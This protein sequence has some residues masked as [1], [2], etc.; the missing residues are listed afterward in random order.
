[1]HTLR[2]PACVV[3]SLLPIL[4]LLP[5]HAQTG[6][7]LVK[8]AP[9]LSGNA[10]V[11]GSIQ[12][13]QPED[14]N[15][16]GNA[17]LTQKL[18]VPGTPK[19]RLNGS[20]TYGGLQAGTGSA[21]PAGTYQITLSGNARLGSLVNRTNAVVLPAMAAPPVSAG[22]RVVVIDAGGQSA[23]D[24]STVRELKVT[25]D[26][27][28][29]AV[30]PG[31]Y[32][33]LQ[34]DG[35]TG[36]QL[37]VAGSAT[38]LVYNVDQLV[39][40]GSAQ[41]QVLSPVI[42][43]VRTKVAIESEVVLGNP[44]HP[45]WLR[46]N[47]YE[48]GLR[49][50][51][52]AQVYARV[53]A[54]TSGND[55]LVKLDGQALLKGSI[56][57][58]WLEVQGQGH[59]VLF[60]YDG[61]TPTNHPPMANA[62]QVQATEDTPEAVALTGS[63]PDGDALTFTITTPPAH[64]ALSG[65]APALIYTP[66][67]NYSGP[68]AFVFKVNDGQLDSALA[69]VSLN[70][71]AVNDPPVA[72]AQTVTLAEDDS[73]TILL[74]GTDVEGAVLSFQV[75]DP[76]A[77]GTLSGTGAEVTYTPVANFN[78]TDTFRFVS[79]DGQAS[80][81]PASVTLTITPV[82][83][84][85]LAVRQSLSTLED[86]PL[87]VMLS[88][89]DVDGD[90]L[91]CTITQPPA[92]GTLSG[93]APALIYTPAGNFN[94]A[95]AFTFTVS[96]G[97]LTAQAAVSV[98]VGP[99]NDAPFVYNVSVALDEDTAASIEGDAIDFDFDALAFTAI[100]QPAH[101]MLTP[102]ATG[103]TYTPAANFNGTDSFTYR[104]NDGLADSDS[105]TVTLTVRAVND[106]PVA[107]AGAFSVVEDTPGAIGLT[108]TDV[109]GDTLSFII[110][111]QPPHGTLTLQSTGWSYAPEA[112]WSGTDSFTFKASDGQLESA[113]ATATVE[114]IS[115]NDAP[116]A[117]AQSVVLDED[118]PASI[119]LTGGD[120]EDSPLS[121]VVLTL[122]AHGT[123]TGDAP[124]LLY[125]PFTDYN[126]SDAFSFK[127]NDGTDDSPAATISL[128][129]NPVN[130]A[131]SGE[132]LAVV[133][134]EDG[135]AAIHLAAA[136]ADGDALTY[137]I[138]RQ[139]L[140][141]TLTGVPPDLNY[142]PDPDFHGTD[143]FA[144]TAS[145][146]GSTSVEQEITLTVEPRNDPPRATPQV[147]STAEDTPLGLTLTGTDVDGDPLIFEVT[148]QPVH[149]AFSG[150]VPNLTYTPA[151]DFHGTDSFT[152]RVSDGQLFSDPIGVT[153][154][155][156]PVNDAPV[157][158]DVSAVT[159]EDTAASVPLVASDVD[160]NTLA[161]EITQAPA[162][163]QVTVTGTVA[164]YVP[165]ADY[166]GPDAFSFRAFDGQ[167]HSNEATVSLTVTPAND[168]PVAL[169]A[170][171]TTEEDT[172]VAIVLHATDVD[173]DALSYRV[174]TPPAHGTLSGSAPVLTYTP[175]ADYT[176][177]DAFAFVANDGQADSAPAIITI[178]VGPVN[179]APVAAALSITLNEDSSA[180]IIASGSDV[181]GD[182]LTFTLV[183]PPQH[184]TLVA[185]I[186]GW[187]YTPAQ[188]FHGSDSFTYRAND[189]QADSAPALAS[190]TVRPVND[191]P[192]AAAQS[193]AG[194]E[195]TP[196]SITLTG[197]DVD[198]DELTFTIATPPAHGTVVAAG[199]S[200][201][202]TPAADYAGPDSFAFTAYDGE[203]H[204]A[205]AIVTLVIAAVND[206]PV[207][208]AR[209]LVL[210][211]DGSAAVTL[212]A[213]DVEE[214]ALSFSV[215]TPPQHGTLSGSA[216]NLGYTPA[217]DYH[218]SDSFT[219]I[220]SD[221]AAG[222]APAS[223]SITVSPVNDAP[224]A[225]AQSA[226]V[227]E[228][229]SLVLT[230]SGSDVDG[231]A[232]TFAI[233][234]P[235]AH[236]VLSGTA[237]N[238]TYT[239]AP[240]YSGSDSFSFTVNDGALTSTPGT[241]SIT[242]VPVNDAPTADAG[243]DVTVNAG[244]FAPL[245]GS[246]SDDG[247]PAGNPLTVQ[248]SKISGPG[249]LTLVS[250]STAVAAVTTRTAGTYVVR[251]TASDG[252]LQTSDEMTLT[253]LAVN[254][255]PVVQ[256][257]GDQSLTLGTAAIL[258]GS[259]TDDGLPDGSTLSYAWTQ[260]SG[261]APATFGS[262]TLANTTASFAKV[263]T[264][265][266][267]LAASDGA[268][269]G[270]DEL[271]V[272]VA[273]SNL[274]PVVDA[275]SDQTIELP[276]MVT[277]TGS[278]TDD[279]LPDTG[280][281]STLWSLV[282]GPAGSSIDAPVALSST[283]HFAQPGTYVFE[284]RANDTLLQ[285]A[286]TVSITVIAPVNRAP[287]VN[288]GD[289]QTLT[290]PHAWLAGTATD[291]A[292]PAGSAVG[293]QWSQ[294]SG[295]GAVAFT[296]PQATATEATF[297]AVGDYVVRL[298]ASDGELSTGDELAI[299]V[300]VPN[301]A[302]VVEAGA[303]IAMTDTFITSL[304]GTVSDEGLPAGNVVTA[305]W[306][307]VSG[308]GTVT[309]ANAGSAGTTAAFSVDGS[310]VLKLVASD[311]ELSAEDTLSVTITDTNIA[312]VVNAGADQSV[313]FAI[314]YSANLITNPSADLPLVSGE[315][316]G[317]TEFTG[318]T[319]TTTSAVTPK[320]GTSFFYPGAMPN[321]ELRQNVDLSAYAAAIDNGN[322]TFEF[323]GFMY[324]K[325]GEERFDYGQIMLQY[326][327]A[328]GAALSEEFVLK[329]QAAA[330]W[331]LLA[332]RGTAPVGARSMRIKL[333][334]TQ[335]SDTNNDVYFDALS[336]KQVV[337]PSVT[338]AGSVT[339]D[340]KPGGSLLSRQWTQTSGP[341]DAILMT[342]RSDN[343]EA[344]F[345][346]AGT[347]TFQFKGDDSRLSATD[348]V[349][350]TVTNG[351]GNRPPVVNAGADRNVVFP[352][353]GTAL[354]GTITD[355]L[356]APAQLVVTWSKADGP[357]TV[358]FSAPNTLATSV[359]FS[360]E[361]TYVLRLTGFDGTHISTD[362]VTVVAE[363][364][365]VLLPVDLMFVIDVSGSMVGV[366]ASNAVIAGQSLVDLQSPLTDRVGLV[367]FSD[368]ATL[369]EVLTS[370]FTQVKNSIQAL[371]FVGGTNIAA[372]LQVAKQELLDHGRM[373]SALPVIVLLSDGVSD[374]ASALTQASQAKASG[375][376]IIS[377]GLGDDADES[378][379]RGIA[380]T[381]ADYFYSP[382]TSDMTGIMADIMG[383]LV[384]RDELGE[385]RV[386]AGGNT[387]ATLA[388]PLTLSGR[389]DFTEVPATA[390]TTIEWTK[391]SGP[392]TVTFATP[393]SPTSAVTFSTPGQYV[394][395]LS[396]SATLGLQYISGKSEVTIRVDM[397]PAMEPPAG[398]IASMRGDGTAIEDITSTLPSYEGYYTS[399]RVRQGF[400]LESGQPVL[401]YP[402]QP[403]WDV[404]KSGS[405]GFSVEFWFKP[406]YL[407][408][409]LGGCVSWDD[410]AGNVM[411]IT[412]GNGFNST[413]QGVSIATTTN[414]TNY[415]SPGVMFFAHSAEWHHVAFCYD[416]T[417]GLLS[418]YFD[419]RV[420]FSGAWTPNPVFSRGNLHIG[421]GITSYLANG[422]RFTLDEVCIYGRGLIA[423]EVASIYNAGSRGKALPSSNRAPVV[424]AGMDQDAPGTLPVTVSLAGQAVDDGE[425]VGIPLSYSWSVADGPG[426]ANFAPAT[427]AVTTAT[428]TTPGTYVLGLQATDSKATGADWL[429]VHAGTPPV[430][431]R[432]SG[433]RAW[434]RF[435]NTPRD[436]INGLSMTLIGADYIA[437]KAGRALNFEG[438]AGVLGSDDSAVTPAHPAYQVG[439]SSPF[440]IE[441]WL[442]LGTSQSGFQSVIL[443][444]LGTGTTIPLRIL[445]NY[446]TGA[447]TV[448]V[449]LQRAGSSVGSSIP[450]N[451][452]WHHCVV[453][454]DPNWVYN[455]FNG[456]KGA[457]RFF[458][459]GVAV[460]TTGIG[461]LPAIAG[462][463]VWRMGYD[464]VN[465]GRYPLRGAID[466][467]SLYDRALTPSEITALYNAGSW[468]KTMQQA[469]RA[470]VASAN[471]P[472]HAFPG[473]TVSLVVSAADDGLPSGNALTYQWTQTN[474]PT[475][476]ISDETSTNAHATLPAP[477]IY[478]FRCTVSDG[479]LST[480]ADLQIEVTA[481]GN[482]APVVSAGPD[483]TLPIGTTSATLNATA[484]DDGLPFTGSLTAYW[485]Q[486]SGPGTVTF[487]AT[488]L[489]T[490]VFF[491]LPGTYVLRLTAT[492]DELTSSDDVVITLASPANQPPTVELGP[493][494]SITTGAT[495]ALG[496][497]LHDD[498]L[499][500]S[501]HL[502]MRWL[503]LS[504]PASPVF[505]PNGLGM[506]VTFPVAGV[507]TIKL[508]ATDGEFEISDQVR[509]FVDVTNAAPVVNAG[510]D[511]LTLL[512]NA[513]TLQGDVSDE[514]LPLGSSVTVQWSQV[515]GPGNATFSAGSSAQTSV[516]FD[517]A[518][519]YV[520]RLSA[521]DGTLSADD[522]VSVR[523]FDGPQAPMIT[524]TAPVDGT[525]VISGRALDL[526]AS[527]TDA[528]G[529][530]AGVEFFID[531]TSAGSDAFAPY[532]LHR[533]TGVT[534]GTHTLTAVATDNEGRTTTSA[535][536]TLTALD[537]TPAQPTLVITSPA[538]GGV[539]TAPTTITGTADYSLMK[540]W[541]VSYRPTDVAGAVW[542]T[543]GTGTT[544]VVSGS[545]GTLDPTLLENGSYD[546][547]LTLDD[548]HDLTWE[549]VT[550][551]AADGAM[552]IGQFTL[553]FEDFK[554]D[555]PGIPISVTRTYDSRATNRPGDFGPGWSVGLRSVRLTK[556]GGA[557]GEGWNHY[558]AGSVD[559]GGF[560]LLIYAMQPTSKK[561]V[562]L[563]F[564]GGRCEIF[565][566]S[567]F[568]DNSAGYTIGPVSLPAIDPNSQY[569]SPVYVGHV[570][571]KPVGP[572]RG[573]L[574]VAGSDRF[575]NLGGALGD[576]T[577]YK[578][579]DLFNAW[580]TG[581]FVF[582]DDDGTQYTLNESS[583]LQKV[584][585]RNGNELT[586]TANAL[587]HSNGS[588]AL[589]TRD[590]QGRITTLT[591]PAG[592]HISYGYN[593]LGT[594]ASVTDRVGN[595]TTFQYQNT[596]HPLYLTGI[597]DPRGV[598]A[599]RTEYD[600]DGRMVRQIDAD[601]HA[602]QLQ[603]NLTAR[604]QKIT[605]RLGHVTTHYFDD[606]GNIT[607]SVDALGHQTTRT[608]DAND[609]EL[610]VADPLGH[611]TSR[612]YDAQNNVT[613]ETDA[614]G[615]TTHYTFNDKKQPLTITDALGR[616]T[617][618]AYDSDGNMTSM[619]DAL[620]R[621]TGFVA[622]GN[623]SISR[624]Q[625]PG[626]LA[627]DF[628]LDGNGNKTSQVV[629][630]ADGKVT[631]YQ[632]FTYNSAGDITAQADYLVPD[633][634]SDVSGATK[635]RTT[636][637]DFDAEGNMTAMQMKDA[638]G[639][640]LQSQSW[641][642]DGL[643]N[644][645]SYTDPLGRE[646]TH[647]Y[648]A[649]GRES[650]T[651]FHDGTTS[652]LEYDA[653]GRITRT[654]NRGNGVNVYEFDALGQQTKA[655]NVDG[656]FSTSTFDAAGR[657][658]SKT[659]E[660]GHTSTMVYDDANRLVSQT[661]A[662]GETTAF[663]LDAT[664]NLIAETDPA[665]RTTTTTLDALGRPTRTDF[666]DG[667]FTT[668]S[669]DAAGRIASRTDEL[670]RT[671][672]QEYDPQGR[673]TAVIDAL[674][675]RTTVAYDNIGRIKQ[676]TDA[677]GN[678]TGYTHDT[679]GR[680]T[681]RTLPGGQ[682]E[683]M[684]WDAL[685]H[686]TSRTDFA[687][688]TTTYFYNADDQLIEKR[689]DPAHPSL[690]LAHAAAKVTY[691]YTDKSQPATATVFNVSDTVLH[692]QSWSYD[693]YGQL[694][695]T[696][697]PHGSLSY[698]H[699][700]MG[701]I[702]SLASSH[703]EA[704]QLSY[705]RDGAS[706]LATITDHR[707]TPARTNNYIYNLAGA[708]TAATV[709]NGMS[710]TF[711]RST[712]DFVTGLTVSDAASTSIESFGYT[713]NSLGQRTRVHEGN[714]RVV[715]YQRD[716]LGRLTQES[717]TGAPPM[718]GTISYTHNAN[719]Y[720][721]AR[722]S[723]QPSVPSQTQTV[724]ANGELSGVTYDANGNPTSA[725]GNTDVFDFENRLIRRTKPDGTVIDFIYD[726]NGQRVEKR[727]TGTQPIGY[728]IDTQSPSGW[729]QCVAEVQWQPATANWEPRTTYTYG[730]QGPI[731]QWTAT[732][733]EH[734]FLLDAHGN[735]RALTDAPGNIVA[736]KDYDAYGLPLAMSAPNAPKSDLG[737][738]GEYFDADLGMIYLRARWY[739][740]STGRFH[741]RDPYQGSFE[742]PMS[743]QAY[744]FAHGDP[745]SMLDPS[746]NFSLV[747]QLTTIAI[748][749]S[750]KYAQSL[751]RFEKIGEPAIREIGSLW[752]V[753]NI[754]ASW[755]SLYRNA[756]DVS[757]T[758]N[759][760]S[761]KQWF[762]QGY[763][764][765][766]STS[767]Q[768]QLLKGFRKRLDGKSPQQFGKSLLAFTNVGA[769]TAASL[770]NSSEWRG[771][772]YQKMNGLP[773]FTP[774]T[775]GGASVFIRGGAD[776]DD[777][778]RGLTGRSGKDETLARTATRWTK[779]TDGTWHHHEVMGIM[780]FVPSSLNNFIGRSAKGVRHSGGTAFWQ[781]MKNR[782]YE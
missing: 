125:T 743:M 354:T 456:S 71:I 421:K 329:P 69:T 622:T 493:D 709:A 781:L 591:D 31:T 468:G 581:D 325:G 631:A 579:N 201:L 443:E 382:T 217:A 731:S 552:K 453:L 757:V 283:V 500:V 43:N 335:T 58:N 263:G 155:V 284:L 343:T 511:R 362:E 285:S 106:A 328:V 240:D 693:A 489:T 639:T 695:G 521:T 558:Q 518:G 371:P 629:R 440:S 583:G 617:S 720:R 363:C 65:N 666:A 663:T 197:S 141:G 397:S 150:T 232:L 334:A 395:R 299:H 530:I 619:T 496:T 235:P 205:P 222:S 569:G 498:G 218:G 32:A 509:V 701:Q 300:T 700:A 25:G 22:T 649:Q 751:Q 704:P 632:T 139:P 216:P 353:A 330:Q 359:M 323:R 779:G 537:D 157:A 752:V 12:Q 147:L 211:E 82:N 774:F 62:L 130:D 99:V 191:A 33:L 164:R 131:P 742:D 764:L 694:T 379:L 544:A 580:D 561:R 422:M 497:D 594:L 683:H 531:G 492:D 641:T 708:L 761:A 454:Y 313:P 424:Q 576:V 574:R 190:L 189:G 383:Q 732:Q 572:S 592:H 265:V 272:V 341:L 684:T 290:T 477:G 221:G 547:R 671:T 522:D 10:W 318:T 765:L 374:R 324:S 565:E 161:F 175:N 407:G 170:Q 692:T 163:G 294:V 72:D 698:T 516:N 474:G 322:A 340:G 413:T 236:G 327:S 773:E 56:V 16:A 718:N 412:V 195:D 42:L 60:D 771:K 79:Q 110:V 772:I 616:V 488:A 64:G 636:H 361:G 298:T 132:A 87:V 396:A 466:E 749:R 128:T 712:R 762:R 286:D 349:T 207:A 637:F 655:I 392:G 308:P 753:L 358:T 648:D 55:G 187:T 293:Y 533:A 690:A 186:N 740:P 721:S 471:A 356:T 44:L 40:Q 260:V 117:S 112:D 705:Q 598:Q 607:R 769:R 75:V 158:D 143:S 287:V 179:D 538:D 269:A 26:A 342:P 621:T 519:D 615:H 559:L 758:T 166:Q 626:G 658:T 605:D 29:V 768:V 451:G 739:D 4:P 553:A 427:Q 487:G 677:L 220:A 393:D 573:A 49:A 357:G 9:M 584:K 100:T 602:V 266:L 416:A 151:P 634:A 513:L 638:N 442:N 68:D 588:A 277:L 1:M 595:V 214:E 304:A 439:N 604:F 251:L 192:V 89:S 39:L 715:Q 259:V 760:G 384:C 514:G 390:T 746:G 249:A 727:K 432:P 408:S 674:G 452:T 380:S 160:G 30:P 420:Q 417:S 212:A 276:G 193:A 431:V 517:A 723:T 242:V 611:T 352:N 348:S 462:T 434:W 223:V 675:Q 94:G 644:E 478:T 738:N 59:V 381:S 630:G 647:V 570:V 311:G 444:H 596:A 782:E 202:Y 398:M 557:L 149:G 111:T 415:N 545:L 258:N 400:Q 18:L 653:E 247:E 425:P 481:V 548:L 778:G 17:N 681:S 541:S 505:A 668:V 188:D 83:D 745:E 159:M 339:D 114:V 27:G 314:S 350:I 54:S 248:W 253:V 676:W 536:V 539:I 50:A 652:V 274:A 370:N 719:G 664:G 34:A 254:E 423:D 137:T 524:L 502:A 288:A 183:T 479:V 685:N 209:S 510:A 135:S 194:T 93:T 345:D 744:L 606:R 560:P 608:Y 306:S 241:V 280:T 296:T 612:T 419:G 291:D 590:A 182:A 369:R 730:P 3:S 482:Q 24:F 122:P 28:I 438:I 682:T 388:S 278:A 467:L 430:S 61:S 167:A 127:V 51:G 527:A 118:M 642:Y 450:L 355:D 364:S 484:T 123:L 520:L 21:S 282:S 710:H 601:G 281:L 603:H 766:Q 587:T 37:G 767:H 555:A 716:D 307:K 360:R 124:N 628:T 203:L 589:F 403:A 66:A 246:V 378:L 540:S 252:A 741:T 84:A 646:T 275:G 105:A 88:G 706:R 428:F 2:L 485:S 373:T 319:W 680:R 455:T 53:T 733:G 331:L 180:T 614:L 770:M 366:K 116:S 528:D 661:N 344:F 289:D 458:V 734:H 176:G 586:I 19:V 81:I 564:P 162:H 447:S 142:V 475:I 386:Y 755:E 699:D 460:G 549:V 402:K 91:A 228:D 121:Y 515:S 303:N 702:D 435:D 577:L 707:T 748:S 556:S 394:L 312:P 245:N 174:A 138:T 36:I 115:V 446:T 670:G 208:Q 377:I 725:N 210:D 550:S 687:G 234:Q 775:L 667:T 535:S 780:Q 376:R 200:W 152:F 219:F 714:G 713:L 333:K 437:G 292:L 225:Q 86:T 169:A 204:S 63:D 80:S 568:F 347:Y 113:P 133:S 459:D 501:S 215:V 13:M 165:A 145:D 457:L 295:P 567:V 599:I 351:A 14:L 238:V 659:D 763:A 650:Q 184:G 418:G 464:S 196:L 662:A 389:V 476:T 302:P 633:G 326:I 268:L 239:P 736:A 387:D 77:H 126:G 230:L 8:H 101:G 651:T 645:L 273:K 465:G 85:P 173:G 316:P 148:A 672:Q 11:E 76:P 486:V 480:T 507:Y 401:T 243:A 7:A 696:T 525:R 35:S 70:V 686:L 255:A 301:R 97:T 441:W 729:P 5:L 470:P 624:L 777:K 726:A 613:S 224:L 226:S 551:F 134:A 153:L 231:D 198:G 526:A 673:S 575:V 321:A 597:T 154:T 495:V 409:A 490:P 665:G 571:F 399:G 582:T 483:Q 404:L 41:L 320:E 305:Q 368:T 181:D 297:S 461:A 46:L 426:S 523:V 445:T 735:V 472:S 499:P 317:W 717:I 156:T 227:D 654:K 346:T 563:T 172:A 640:V 95:D 271:T 367:S 237:P 96:D 542:T 372:G 473:E 73:A 20:P 697:T 728:L 264:Y 78:G 109:D 737:Y 508:I 449:Y 144:F 618:F 119:T 336:L 750:T 625:F 177:G 534:T 543:L 593:T 610:T 759:P 261:P 678:V 711:Q 620:G 566:A 270:S 689:A 279:G 506:N 48:S 656:T 724:N 578:E 546:L 171:L 332:H 178:D 310:Y 433:L 562:V 688:F 375:I 52:A 213:T 679:I 691:T 585:D 250:S 411:A 309:F 391:V 129:V 504:A 338:L 104:A 136:D 57:A 15:Q 503:T 108:G 107:R 168:A 45:E 199:D 512:A 643:G 448:S 532:A 436:V 657:E 47:D 660:L 410:G 776:A 722:T 463:G 185:T 491:T 600:A 267:R 529:S 229:T 90:A 38:P 140:H 469:N 747:E 385:V 406:N 262:T 554:L 74:T 635:L 67:T 315:I 233:A 257:G 337:L 23:G 146:E 703:P 98:V 494:Q 429:T 365:G 256:A 206:A 244:E 754:Y 756:F 103:W 623:G 627:Y 405:Q 414:G 6:T 120:L 92:H 669:Y 609:R 102:S